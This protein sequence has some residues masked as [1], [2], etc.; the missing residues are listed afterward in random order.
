[1][2]M[3]KSQKEIFNILKN[4]L[5]KNGAWTRGQLLVEG[6]LVP[7]RLSTLAGLERRGLVKMNSIWFQEG[8]G[9]SRQCCSVT[10]KEDV[11]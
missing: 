1:M 2:R 6:E 9:P 8:V 4:S 7:C 3:S 11:R 5:A 10:V